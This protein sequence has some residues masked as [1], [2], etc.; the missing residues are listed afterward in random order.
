[1]W[2]AIVGISAMALVQAMAFSFVERVGMERGFGA[3]SITGVL[4]ALGVV[5]LLPAALAAM[6]EKRWLSH[7]VLR[8][9]PCVQA[10][11]VLVIMNAETFSL[12][13]VAVSV[14]SAVMIFT[15]TFA[16]GLM[17]KRDRS[18][19]ALAATPAMLMTGAAIGPI[20]GGTLVK[21]QGFGSLSLVA[22]VIAVIAVIC[23]SRI[24]R[25]ADAPV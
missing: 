13:A 11:L 1:V 19:R 17:A 6:L 9:G 4:I 20:L 21:F 22:T 2:Y 18:G 7:L 24:P 3:Q 8:A 23:F 5:N 14:L 12:Y 10:V 16:F 25:S 15:H